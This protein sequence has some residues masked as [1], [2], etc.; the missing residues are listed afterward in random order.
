M[1][2]KK[3]QPLKGEQQQQKKTKLIVHAISVVN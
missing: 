1:Q 2:R 3:N